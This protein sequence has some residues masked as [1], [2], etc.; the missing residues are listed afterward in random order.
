MDYKRLIAPPESKVLKSG[1]VILQPGQEVGE[2][3]T[4]KREEI[5]IVLKGE[6][7]LVNEGNKIILKEHETYYIPEEKKHN[8][9]NESD[10]ELKY[11][12]VVSLFDKF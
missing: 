8:V 12:Y 11:V 2:H 9:M 4:D 1:Q 3:V 5:L 10:K 6:A 7:T